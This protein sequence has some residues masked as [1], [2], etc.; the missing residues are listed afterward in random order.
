MVEWKTETLK[1]FRLP[2]GRNYLLPWGGTQGWKYTGS[3]LFV[4]LSLLLWLDKTSVLH[5]S[6]VFMDH[7]TTVVSSSSVYRVD[8]L[9]TFFVQWSPE[10]YGKDAK[11]QGFVVVEKEELDMIDN[12]FS[13]P[14]T[15][16]WE[17]SAFCCCVK[18]MKCAAPVKNLSICCF[19]DFFMVFLYAYCLYRSLLQ[20]CICLT[21]VLIFLQSSFLPSLE[22]AGKQLGA[23]WCASS[24]CA[25]I[26][27]MW[28]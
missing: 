26:L 27:V 17:V 10:I 18:H 16:S 13:E 28:G 5:G 20:A 19:D 7:C 6:A 12:F 8:H 3:T 9:Y 15:K 14:T 11:E 1:C 24:S 23:L 4:R 25:N 21:N 2:G 22:R